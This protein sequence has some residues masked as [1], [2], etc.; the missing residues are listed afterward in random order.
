MDYRAHEDFV[1]PARE[2][3]ELWRTLAGAL[4]AVIAGLALYQAALAVLALGVGDAGMRWLMDQTTYYADTPFATLVVLFSFAFFGLGTALA[5]PAVHGRGVLTLLGGWEGAVSDFMRVTTATLGLYLLLLVVLPQDYALER[6]AA[7]PTGLWL[8][9]MPLSLLAVM[10]QAGSEE[11]FFRGYL[12]QQL[13]ARL[14]WPLWMLVPSALF[15]LAHVSGEAGTGWIFGLWALA[16]GLAAA[17]LTA[18]TGALGAAL[19]LHFAN[20]AVAI[21]V[22]AL[23]GPGSGLALWHVPRTAAELDAAMLLPEL[24][25]LFCAWLAARLALRV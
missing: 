17:D 7:L 1:A 9:L 21:L 11:L 8:A 3:A 16:F 18:R 13:A 5:V 2:R 15:G 10:V 4:T 14:P 19:G 12:Q 6:N 24:G 25:M 20:N 23:A 22:T